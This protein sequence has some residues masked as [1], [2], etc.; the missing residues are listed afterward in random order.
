MLHVRCFSKF[1]CRWLTEWGWL[2]GWM[3]GWLSS[4][5]R[6]WW[7]LQRVTCAQL[8]MSSTWIYK[9]K[10]STGFVRFINIFTCAASDFTFSVNAAC[11]TWTL[12]IHVT[13]R[14]V[15]LWFH[16]RL[17]CPTARWPTGPATHLATC[18][19]RRPLHPFHRLGHAHSVA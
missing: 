19:P 3:D 4:R 11:A 18:A 7:H 10:S 16:A 5:R 15:R 9:L 2:D 17:T 13:V 1:S 8:K 6:V 12:S 14:F